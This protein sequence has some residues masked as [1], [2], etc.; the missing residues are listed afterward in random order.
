[1][2]TKH[3]F[4]QKYRIELRERDH[5]PAHVHLTGGGADVLIWLATLD[6]DG[7]CPADVKAEAVE[8]VK[9]HLDE[10]TEDWKKWHG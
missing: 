8:W 9:A 6:T 3:R 7:A 2:T 4:R 1:M 10:L 5:G